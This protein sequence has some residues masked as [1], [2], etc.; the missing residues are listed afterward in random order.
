LKEGEKM[1]FSYKVE[2]VNNNK[3]IKLTLKGDIGV[4]LNAL[5]TLKE[6]IDDITLKPGINLKVDFAKVSFISSNGISIIVRGY[7][8][9]AQGKGEF[10]LLNLNP[11]IYSTFEILGLT[12]FLNVQYTETEEC[13]KAYS[14]SETQDSKKSCPYCGKIIEATAAHCPYCYRWLEE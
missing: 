9:V 14:V 2:K 6:V 4:N 11:Q 5:Q 12:D 1:D 8:R 3:D 10:T 13:E 7:K